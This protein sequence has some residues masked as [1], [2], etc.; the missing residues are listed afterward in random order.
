MEQKQ[1]QIKIRRKNQLNTSGNNNNSNENKISKSNTIKISET[2]TG[3]IDDES[4]LLQI[5]YKIYDETLTDGT[6]I[7]KNTTIHENN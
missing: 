1:T 2:F 4:D 5:G 6:N 3:N 7:V